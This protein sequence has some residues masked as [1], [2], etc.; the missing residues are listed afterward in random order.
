[1]WLRNVEKKRHLSFPPPWDPQTLL[2]SS[3]TPDFL[4]TCLGIDALWYSHFLK[5][6]PYSQSLLWST[7]SKAY[8]VVNETEV[9]G[10]LEFLC[11]LYD[12][13]N[14]DNLISGS[15][16]FSKPRLYNWKFSVHV[17]LKEFAH[18]LTSMWNEHNCTVVR[19]F[20][21][22]AL[23]WDWNENWPF[24]VLWPLP[25]FQNLLIL[26]VTL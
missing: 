17:L 18:T 10:F 12:P 16:D 13:V 25:S 9:D 26:R 19:T 22:T 15:S 20:F 2:S 21:G 11:F 4:S 14:V 23:L 7:Q 24:P 3:G 1:M 5:S 8:S 6:F